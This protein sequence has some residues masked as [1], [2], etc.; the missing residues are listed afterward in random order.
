MSVLGGSSQLKGL[1]NEVLQQAKSA[2]CCFND[3]SFVVSVL[4]CEVL[5]GKF[6]IARR[7]RGGRGLHLR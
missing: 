6:S 1:L 4:R 5:Y 2:F 7:E 3:H